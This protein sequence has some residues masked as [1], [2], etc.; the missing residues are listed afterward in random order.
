MADITDV[1]SDADIAV[2]AVAFEAGEA[3]A[4]AAPA[5]VIVGGIRR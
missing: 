1:R 5:T 3:S 2:R 4:L